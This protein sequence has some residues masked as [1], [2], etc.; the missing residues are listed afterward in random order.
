MIEC[1]GLSS[2][3]IAFDCLESWFAA[4]RTM[5]FQLHEE[6]DCVCP[7][8]PINC[9]IDQPPKC[10]NPRKTHNP[11]RTQ[12]SQTTA[13]TGAE[14]I[15]AN[16]LFASLAL[17]HVRPRRRSI[18]NIGKQSCSSHDQQLGG[19]SIPV[20]QVRSRITPRSG[21][22][23]TVPSASPDPLLAPI[24]TLFTKLAGRYLRSN[25]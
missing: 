21:L 15:D 10:W 19:A 5:L 25:G 6:A 24:E 12:R 22:I 2:I 7:D 18:A 11:R 4:L 16:R 9:V 1:F 14:F 3:V 13:K 20:P 23:K 17:H 8:A